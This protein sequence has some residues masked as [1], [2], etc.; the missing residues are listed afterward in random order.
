MEETTDN[1]A[2]ITTEI[3][4][5]ENTDNQGDFKC[6]LCDRHYCSKK[7]L[8]NHN[9]RIHEI[10]NT[11]KKS[12]EDGCYHC[13][14]CNKGYKLIQ[15][16][17]CHQKK[18]EKSKNGSNGHNVIEEMN[19]MKEQIAELQ[20]KLLTCKRLD[21][22]TFKAVNQILMD[23]SYYNS[24]NRITNNYQILSLGNEE[25]VNV[26]T[27]EQKKMILNSRLGSLEKIVEIAHCGELNQFK[28]IIITN[29]KDQYAYRY[30]NQKGYFVTITKNVLLENV[31]AHRV[32]DIE[33]IYDELKTA[34]KID[35]KTK[36]LIQDFLD[37]MSDDKIPFYDNDIKYE[38]F[39]TFKL[40]NIKILLYNNQDKITKDIALLISDDSA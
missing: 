13:K 31:V 10:E 25:L 35:S 22:T 1:T 7:G 39:K 19:K 17:W 8:S 3:F 37:R 34:K 21:N 29:L 15:S 36:K 33:A 38:N 24:N 2:T 32:T 26:L 9:R 27:M 23:R 16:R 14:Y 5:Q 18:C 40:D 4:E 20:N 30:D 12:K 6:S 28:N 11:K